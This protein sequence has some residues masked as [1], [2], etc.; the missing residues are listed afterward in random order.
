VSGGTSVNTIA[1][2][3]S[4]LVDIRSN[5][6]QALLATEKQI[7]AAIESGVREENARWGSTGIR[8]VPRLVGDRAAGRSPA[9]SPILKA[10]ID[11]HRALGLPE[12]AIGTSSTDSNVPIGFGIPAATMNG[13]GIGG[14]AH[15]P[16]EWYEPVEGWL[17]P[18]TVLLTTLAL[19]GVEGAI[20]P[21][22][23][24]APRSTP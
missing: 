4:M 18:Q 14:G 21:Q 13:G 12:P 22:L 15:S 7:M 2:E 6:A 10:G 8:A 3:A 19:V 17:G 11:A 20:K 23:V 24:V 16:G 9:D 5:D 1:A